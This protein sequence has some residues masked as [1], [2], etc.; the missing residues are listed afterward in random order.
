MSSSRSSQTACVRKGRDEGKKCCRLQY[1]GLV[2]RHRRRRE[3]SHRLRT[4]GYSLECARPVAKCAQLTTL[5]KQ[6]EYRRSIERFG[7]IDCLT[8]CPSK[9]PRCS[10]TSFSPCCTCNAPDS[11][12]RP[13]KNQKQKKNSSMLP[14]IYIYCFAQYIFIHGW[15][16]TCVNGNRFVGSCSSS[17]NGVLVHVDN[18]RGLVQKL[19]E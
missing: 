10:P 12:K 16:I 14:Y 4:R 18:L 3:V 11:Q 9:T 8:K 13:I 7:I 2:Q 19:T 1:P 17:Y 6:S 5:R 15:L